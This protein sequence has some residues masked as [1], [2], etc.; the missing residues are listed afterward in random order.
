L[1]GGNSLARRYLPKE[2]QIRMLRDLFER[3]N[4]GVGA[5]II[6]W[7]SYVTEKEYDENLENLRRAYP[8]YNWET[9]APPPPKT[10]DEIALESLRREVEEFGGVI[11]PARRW[12][13]LRDI[14]DRVKFLKKELQLQKKRSEREEALLREK[15][16]EAEKEIE[17]LRRRPEKPPYSELVNSLEDYLKKVKRVGV[18]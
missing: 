16:E 3:L 11:V 4:P 7:E 8:Y 9:P 13:R 2:L 10:Y 14:E 17:R 6:D 5:D 18:F 1:R 12:A 15:L